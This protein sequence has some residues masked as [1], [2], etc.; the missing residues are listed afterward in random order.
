M[1]D[2]GDIGAVLDAAEAQ[3]REA[4]RVPRKSLADFRRDTDGRNVLLKGRWGVLGTMSMH[5]STTGSGKSVLQ[6]QSAL[7]FNRGLPCCGLEPTRPFRTWIIQSEDDEDRVAMD[8]DDIVGYLKGQHPGQDWDAA[9]R[10]TAFLDFTGLTGVRFIETLNGE[11][12]AASSG[13]KPEAIILNPWNK[14]F[15]GDP[16][17]AKDCSAFLAGGELG[18]GETEGIEAVL[19]RH[20]VWLWAFAHTGKPPSA[21]DLKDWLADPYS[22]YKMCGSSVVPDAVR[23]IIT[24]LKV[25]NGDGVFAFTAGKNGAGLGWTDANGNRST[26][27]L[28]QWG[29]GG[30]HYWRD[31]DKALW[32]DVDA[33]QGSGRG[34]TPKPLPPP[35]R[36]ETPLV[37]AAFEA[38]KAPVKKGAAVVEIR[39]VIDDERA[40]ASPPVKPIGRNDATSLLD[41]AIAKGLVASV[42]CG[43]KAGTL[44]GLPKVMNEWR[45]QAL[46][47]ME[48]DGVPTPPAN[49]KRGA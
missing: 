22:C 4:E 38:F 28:F 42:E 2:C 40:K 5:V 35:P 39:K 13:G 48:T 9:A 7:C 18:R 8:R 24:F 10:E 30:R 29:E 34:G 14:F 49:G 44:C 3:A 46:P 19:K 20:G 15:G 17:S 37:V 47:G 1:S 11:L 31:A 27:A 26:R 41:N 12:E 36:N 25:P 33:A 43:G 16:N 6:T 32:A 23:S 21:K 45:N